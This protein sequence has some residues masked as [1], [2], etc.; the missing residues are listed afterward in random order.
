MVQIGN[1]KQ[2]SHGDI[3][4][5]MD[6]P[7]GSREHGTLVQIDRA[8]TPIPVEDDGILYDKFESITVAATSIGFTAEERE[9]HTHARVTVEA[10]A[11]RFRPDGSNIAPTATVGHPIESGDSWLFSHPWVLENIRFIR[12]DGVSATLMVSYGNRR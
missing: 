10:A 5:K 8:N 6:F 2:D 11:V 3:N 4:H 9:G 7:V 12:R 1:E